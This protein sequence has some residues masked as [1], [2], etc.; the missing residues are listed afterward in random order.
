[1]SAKTPGPVTTTPTNVL[2]NL[3][4]GGTDIEAKQGGQTGH[5]HS[6]QEGQAGRNEA[7]RNAAGEIAAKNA[8]NDKDE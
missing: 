8:A 3:I 5:G 4:T 6:S 1:M 7:T 2:T